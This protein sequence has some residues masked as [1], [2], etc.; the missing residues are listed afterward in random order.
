MI[1]HIVL[2]KF[3]SDTDQAEIEEI[4]S[5]LARLQEKVPGIMAFK[6]G[7]YTSP[8]GLNQG[9]THGFTMDF[10]DAAARDIYLPHPEHEKVKGKI[11]K[12]LEGGVGGVIAF[13]YEISPSTEK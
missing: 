8:E 11:I 10:T 4:F 9:F 6:G 1:R 13:D 5:D 12:A 3:K 2:F 7:P